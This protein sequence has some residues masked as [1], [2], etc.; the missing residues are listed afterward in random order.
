VRESTFGLALAY[1]VNGRRDDATAAVDHLL[2]LVLANGLTSYLPS[3]SAFRARLALNDP[4]SNTVDHLLPRHSFD[5]ERDP[6][7]F[8]QFSPITRARALINLRTRGAL[9]EAREVLDG[10]FERTAQNHDRVRLVKLHALKALTHQALTEREEALQ[11]L[12]EAL[13]I[14]EPEHFVRSFVELGSTMVELLNEFARRFGQSPYLNHLLA[15]FTVSSRRI[16]RVLDVRP[17]S[18]LEQLMAESQ[19][20]ALFGLLTDRELEVLECLYRRLS[21]KEIAEQL[22][23][24]PLTVK[25]HASNIY[26]K[27]GVANRRQAIL[28]ASEMGILSP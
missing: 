1:Q 16:D 27:L 15:S 5:T 6:F 25:R 8:I 20:S 4:E 17:I 3:I 2:E 11:S 14:G 24:S 7:H 10:L 9:E 21:N 19:R 23:I 22:Y 28:K 26:D 18:T 13:E 12:S